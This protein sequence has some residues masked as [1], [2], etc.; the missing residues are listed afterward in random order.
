MAEVERI[1]DQLQHAFFGPAYAGPAVI[2]LLSAT[3][4]PAAAAHPI[5]NAHSIWQIVLHMTFWKRAVLCGLRGRA[6]TVG[7]DQDW[8]AII[9]FA[10]EYWDSACK[11]LQDAH[12]EL[13]EAVAKLP[14]SALAVQ[15]PGRDFDVY[16][17][18]HG[19]VQHDMYH[20]GQIAMLRKSF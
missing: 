16:F 9:E 7:K 18:L 11:E 6:V 2:E 14:E 17:M 12:R 4:A 1:S 5:S 19:I 15:V 13:C 3:S 8:P 10:D 20:A